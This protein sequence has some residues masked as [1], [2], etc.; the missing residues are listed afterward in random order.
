VARATAL[1]RAH[2]GL[3]PG[4]PSRCCRDGPSGLSQLNLRVGWHA[5][6]LRRAC[7]LLKICTPFASCS[8]RAT[9]KLSC[10]KALGPCEVLVRT[11]E[12]GADGFVALLALQK[13]YERI[14]PARIGLPVQ[15]LLVHAAQ[16]VL[17]GMPCCATCRRVIPWSRKSCHVPARRITRPGSSGTYL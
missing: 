16:Q 9:R 2:P 14:P 17:L 15:I 13:R 12:Q 10:D 3:D 8:E 7:R 5:L 6:S 1:P 4:G 11:Q